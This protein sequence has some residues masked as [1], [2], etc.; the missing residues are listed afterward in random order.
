VKTSTRS[1]ACKAARLNRAGP[2]RKLD[3]C[4]DPGSAAQR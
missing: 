1:A 2:S 4:M 3:R